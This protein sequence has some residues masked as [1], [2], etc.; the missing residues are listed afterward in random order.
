MDPTF[1]AVY[2][3]LLSKGPGHVT[4]T[5]GTV[6]RIE[7]RNGRI[8][9]FPKSGRINVHEDCWGKQTTCQGTRAGGIYN[10]P[11]C[12]FDWFAEHQSGTGPGRASTGSAANKGASLTE[13]TLLDEHAP[14]HVAAYNARCLHYNL[15]ADGVY[16]ARMR[17]GDP[18]RRRTSSLACWASIWAA[19]WVRAKFILWRLASAADYMGA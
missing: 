18:Y 6:Y 16:R 4:S 13:E 5:R 9:A 17:I 12:I 15:I 2:E 19:Q 3:L 11:Y 10:G 7:G 14:S 1:A 8:I